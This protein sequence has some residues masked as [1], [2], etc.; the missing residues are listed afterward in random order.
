MIECENV[1]SKTTQ[2]MQ[3]R[4]SLGSRILPAARRRLQFVYTRIRWPRVSF[5]SGCDVRSGLWI[6]LG[7]GGKVSF[8]PGCVIDRGMSVEVY[9]ELI[10]GSR[11]IFG[12]HCTLASQSSVTIGDDCLIAELVSVR[13]HDHRFD[14]LD[15]PVREQGMVCAPVKICN[16]VWLGSK[17]TVIKG[18]T[19]GDNA[20]VGANA[21]VTK[22]IPANAVAFGI[23][24]KVVRFR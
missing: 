21:V 9:G 17:V 19:I 14:R 13:D 4:C 5:G 11:T 24:A 3:Q 6:H 12:H 1:L 20:I 2:V 15:I 7:P 10:V 16:N 18:V 23:P 22:D 8:A